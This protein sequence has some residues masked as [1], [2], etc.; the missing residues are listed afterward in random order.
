M[1]RGTAHTMIFR[2]DADRRRM[3]S[4]LQDLEPLFGVR[5]VAFVLMGN[6]YHFLVQSLDRRL[7]DA[8]RHLD[9]R[10]ARG[11]NRDHDRNGALFKARY[12]SERVKD[13][14]QLHRVGIYIHLN[15]IAAGLV[16]HSTDYRWSSLTAYRLGRS[17][18]SWLHL[19]L[20]NGRTGEEYLALVLSYSDEVSAMNLPPSD[21]GSAWWRADAV[22]AE[23]AELL[24]E[25]TRIERAVASKFGVSV[26]EIYAVR[27]GHANVP[28][29]VAIAA[30]RTI[31]LTAS[32]TAERYG[33]TCD[34]SVRST[35]RRVRQR[36]VDDPDIAELLAALQ[37]KI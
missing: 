9:G 29:D 22:A 2:D 19:D 13:E 31:G 11:F 7:G 17:P 4:L 26:D 5:V 37:V 23:H 15:P 16:D 25:A 14:V 32:D 30:A 35:I 10:Y 28:R 34:A 8:M 36:A 3:L 18:M 20:L 12:R 33:L 1:N 21:D 24:A 6:H 27:K